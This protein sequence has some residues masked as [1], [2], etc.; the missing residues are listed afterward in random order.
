M[1]DVAVD[2]A[3]KKVGIEETT[4]ELGQNSD[5]HTPQTGKFEIKRRNLSSSRNSASNSKDSDSPSCNFEDQYMECGH[6]SSLDSCSLSPQPQY[7]DP[8]DSGSVKKCND[9][10]LSSASDVMLTPT[11][12][13]RQN[14][15]RKRSQTTSTFKKSKKT[16]VNTKKDDHVSMD[17]LN[18]GTKLTPNSSSDEDLPAVSM[19]Q[20]PTKGYSSREFYFV[21]IKQMWHFVYF[22]CVV[23]D[24]KSK[25]LVW[26]KHGKDPFWPALV[27]LSI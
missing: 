21:F 19:C 15:S 23:K 20:T 3:N 14:K 17:T 6:K 22:T 8:S 13:E 26:V 25:D 11:R 12:M 4:E 24:I 9:T 16:K 7:L 1:F 2:I 27:R 10:S 5:L 18:N